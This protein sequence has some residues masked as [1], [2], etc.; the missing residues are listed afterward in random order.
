[1][2]KEEYELYPEFIV[3]REVKIRIQ[4]KG[5]RTKEIIIHTSFEDDIEYSKDDIGLLFRRRW[6]AEL[7]LRSIKTVMQMLSLIHI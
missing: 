1:M 7:N 6:Q 5:F 4:Q 2:S 3:V